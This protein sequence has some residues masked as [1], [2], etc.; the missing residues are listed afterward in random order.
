[1]TTA[2]AA[3]TVDITIDAVILDNVSVTNDSYAWCSDQHE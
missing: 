3:A 2:D 1:M